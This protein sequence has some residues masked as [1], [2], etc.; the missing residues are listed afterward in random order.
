M[1]AEADKGTEPGI[2]SCIGRTK[3]EEI[4]GTEGKDTDEIIGGDQGDLPSI[5]GL[6]STSHP[7]IIKSVKDKKA[8]WSQD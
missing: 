1:R 3:R 6:P 5:I 2:W 7:C 4:G 8:M